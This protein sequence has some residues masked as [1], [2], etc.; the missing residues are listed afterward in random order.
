MSIHPAIQGITQDNLSGSQEITNKAS[1]LILQL[2]R[3]RKHPSP[4][5]LGRDLLKVGSRLL[6]AQPVMASLLNLFNT[7]LSALNDVPSGSTGVREIR[8]TTKTFIREMNE[9]NENISNHLFRQV[10][11]KD[12]ILTYS[13]SRSVREALLRC[14]KKGKRFSVICSES[15]PAGEGTLLARRLVAGGIPTSLTTDAL[16]LSLLSAS[17]GSEDRVN[18]ILVSADSVSP[19]GLTNKAGTHPLALVANH[20]SVPFYAL[21]GSEKFFPWNFPVER[22]IPDAPQ[23]EV[24]AHAPRK[25]KIINRIFDVTP[26]TNVTG[27]ITEKGL[28]TSQEMRTHLKKL[29]VHPGL[30]AALKKVY[31]QK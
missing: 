21:A 22:M 20:T 6:H 25:L 1:L 11:T 29:H 3:D 30:M 19:R 16:A 17:H 24:L 12:T 27:I 18:M 9:H 10:R 13:S 31:I 23:K 8:F 5:L 4:E 7:A 15:R 14:W 26:L 28:F 2:L